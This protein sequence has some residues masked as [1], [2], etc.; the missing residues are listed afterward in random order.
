MQIY[1]DIRYTKIYIFA[2]MTFYPKPNRITSTCEPESSL[3]LN[4]M[5]LYRLQSFSL[6][7]LAYTYVKFA[8]T[9]IK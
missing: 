7:H 3:L 1:I 8:K 2:Y 5:Q 9:L 6:Q 4:T